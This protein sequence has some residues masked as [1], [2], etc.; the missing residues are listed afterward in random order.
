MAPQPRRLAALLLLFAAVPLLWT[1]WASDRRRIDRRLDEL[2]EAVEKSGPES[3]LAAVASARAVTELFAEP[4]EVRAEAVGFSTR[5]RRQLMR[6]VH[7]YR[8]TAEHISMR[9]DRESLAVSGEHG[10]A[11]LIAAFAFRSGGPLGD[12]S[13]R[14]RVQVNWKEESDGWRIDYVDLLEIVDG[15][16]GRLGF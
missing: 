3:A 6:W 13:E 8:S 14:Y 7:R 15:P 2:R 9:I 5:D 12:S 1:W 16:G 4:F 11:S 10:R